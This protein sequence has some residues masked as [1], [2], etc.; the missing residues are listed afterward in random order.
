MGTWFDDTTSHYLIKT[1]WSN[2]MTIM[3]YNA[4]WSCMFGK[5]NMNLPNTTSLVMRIFLILM[6]KHW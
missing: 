4:L 3:S 2:G 5:L 6:S 1:W